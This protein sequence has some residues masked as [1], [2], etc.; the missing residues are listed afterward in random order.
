MQSKSD[1]AL[2]TRVSG[3][4][5]LVTDSGDVTRLEP[6]TSMVLRSQVLGGHSLTAIP[7]V[8]V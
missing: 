2:V 4:T 6:T 1:S 8:E 7:D 3:L 5:P